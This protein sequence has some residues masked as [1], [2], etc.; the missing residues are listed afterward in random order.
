[1]S[2]NEGNSVVCSWEKGFQ[3]TFQYRF[4]ISNHLSISYHAPIPKCVVLL[5]QKIL[6]ETQEKLL[7][8]RKI[9][10]AMSLMTKLTLALTLN[11][12]NDDV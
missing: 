10:Y 5:R 8:R 2:N 9:F 1:M 7:L 3:T 11:D 4:Y 6:P 12:T